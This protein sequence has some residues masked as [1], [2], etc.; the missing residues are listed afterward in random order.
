MILLGLA[1]KARSG[2]DTI[3]SYLVERY[4]FVS[5]S[6]SDSLY[7]EVQLA[8][9]LEDQSL[10]REPSTKDETT[11]R[12]ALAA[13]S[14]AAFVEV[15]KPLVHAANPDTFRPIEALELSPR[16]ILQWWGTQYRRAQDDYYWVKKAQEFLQ[17]VAAAARYPE[18][19]QQYFVNTSVRFENERNW[20]AD[21]GG[22][23]WHVYRD[24]IDAV[25][26]HTSEDELPLVG[27][28]REIYNNDTI[29]RLHAGVELL[30][31][32][33]ARFVK[34][35]PMQPDEPPPEGTL[36]VAD[37]EQASEVETVIDGPTT[38]R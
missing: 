9:G 17:A 36:V 2:K 8:F 37:G 20:I 34:V 14:D 24:G 10:L 13:C 27:V 12:M 21:L 19:R 38:E 1:G 30:L 16:Q 4:G 29:E 18:Q 33:G 7:H 11:V 5:F 28:E 3:A 15:A 35:Q 23:V 26:A 6:F 31:N 25:N 22:N 32:T